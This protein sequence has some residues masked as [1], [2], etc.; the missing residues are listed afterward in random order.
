MTRC[1]KA[2]NGVFTVFRESRNGVFASAN[3]FSDGQS[4]VDFVFNTDQPSGSVEAVKIPKAEY[5]RL[6]A[7]KAA[8]CSLA[9][10]REER[11]KDDPYQSWVSNQSL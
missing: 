7:L 8:R 5:V 11:I 4:V 2:T 10:V 3:I 9:G 1:Y 6:V